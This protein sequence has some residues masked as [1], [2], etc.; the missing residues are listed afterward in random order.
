MQANEAIPLQLLLSFI[1]A[2]SAIEFA[3][4][5]YLALIA[6]SSRE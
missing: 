5:K 2:G 3:L 6:T 1:N 4:K